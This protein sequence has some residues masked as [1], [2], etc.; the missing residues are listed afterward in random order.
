MLPPS[1]TPAS[2]PGG[3][4]AWDTSPATQVITVT[5][6]CGF[7]MR[8]TVLNYIPEAQVWG[9]GRIVWVEHTADES[10]QVLK[11]KLGPAEVVQ[12]LQTANSAG[13]FGWQDLFTE[14]NSPT[15][16]PSKCIDIR[17][18]DRAHRVCEY[19]G[20]APQAF[21]DL[22]N[23]LSGGLG[24]S[25]A[26]YTPERGFLTAE[27]SPGPASAEAQAQFPIWDSASLGL[28]LSE[29]A[30]GVWVEGPALQRAWELLKQ[31]P[32][33]GLVRDGDAFYQVSLQI[34][35]ISLSEP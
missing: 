31:Y 28:S 10:I 14:P 32:Y 16:M 8:A 15:D 29:A 26:P 33:G 5:N 24:A 20:G 23:S 25:D 27:A 17:L 21:H 12:V 7:V 34:P 18:V 2:P 3:D 1:Q 22:Y 4:L 11:G 30:S 35:G 6:C 19:V 13:F 9:D